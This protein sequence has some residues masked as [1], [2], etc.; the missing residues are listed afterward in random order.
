MTLHGSGSKTIS[1]PSRIITSH[2]NQRHHSCDSELGTVCNRVRMINTTNSNSN[3]TCS[4]NNGK[5][6]LNTLSAI[7]ANLIAPARAPDQQN[8]MTTIATRLGLHD[9]GLGY[10]WPHDELRQPHLPTPW[11]P[12]FLQP[13]TV[14]RQ[15]HLRQPHLPTPWPLGHPL[16]PHGIQPCLNLASNIRPSWGPRG[17]QKHWN[18]NGLFDYF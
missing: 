15:I 9:L 6:I 5:S 17:S 14:G 7:V 16:G 18:S 3:G 12:G 11:T 1:N 2:I 10:T 4:C 13:L 8:E